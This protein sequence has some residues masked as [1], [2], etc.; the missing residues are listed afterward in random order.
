[1]S[2]QVVAMWERFHL[3]FYRTSESKWPFI[4]IKNQYKDQFSASEWNDQNMD[5]S[6]SSQRKP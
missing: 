1:M 4:G 6:F 2:L 3:A 5:F